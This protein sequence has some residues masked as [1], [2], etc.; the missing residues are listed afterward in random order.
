MT[1][2]P[3]GRLARHAYLELIGN[4]RSL[5]QIGGL[6]LLLG[7]ALAL[8]ARGGAFLFTAAADLTVTLGAAAVAVAWHR[9]LLLGEPF[10]RRVAPLDA[11]VARY[12]FLTVI[13]AFLIGT[14]PALVLLL[15]GGPALLGGAEAGAAPGG[16][17][18]GLL[19]VPI[20]AVA[21]LWVALRVQLIFPATAIADQAMTPARSW[22]LTRGNGGRL[23]LGFV[24]V[25]LPVTAA[26][27]ALSLVLGWLADATGSLVLS[28]LSDLAAVANPL[29]QAP[30]IAAFLSYAYTWFRQ[31]EG[32]GG[33]VPVPRPPG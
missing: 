23:F 6:W 3:F 33:T 32:Q 1:K 19:L 8:L 9:H 10:A 14:T 11:R 28:A 26:M 25:T 18:L 4:G 7:W 16:A 13:L 22:A 31:H 17:G 15:V 5:V 29:L 27:V 12:L 20:V 24:L 2:L 21:C 30:L